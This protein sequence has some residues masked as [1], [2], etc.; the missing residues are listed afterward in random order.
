MSNTNKRCETCRGTGEAATEYGIAD[1]PDCGGSGDLPSRN[2]RVG[3]LAADIERSL[4]RGRP[5]DTEHVRWLLDELR[6]ARAALTEVI[7]LAHD[8]RD[9][10]NISRKI[11]FTANRALG[12]YDV[13]SEPQARES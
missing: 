8:T 13:K 6:L 7:A 10:D 11:R 1:C 2:V 5:V 4:A 3:W 12:L 9:E